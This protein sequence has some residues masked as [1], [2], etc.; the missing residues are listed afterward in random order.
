MTP[1]FITGLALS[2]PTAV[3]SPAALWQDDLPAHRRAS[4]YATI[5]IGARQQAQGPIVRRLRDGR[6]SIE[7]GGRVLTGH[8]VAPRPA[9]GLWARISAAMA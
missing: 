1:N 2:V 7:A 8:A 4:D 3:V 9:P 5:A 6:I